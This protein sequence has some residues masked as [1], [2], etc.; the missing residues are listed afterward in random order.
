MSWSDTKL[1]ESV[2]R[3]SPKLF[4][5]AGVLIL[6]AVLNHSIV[7]FNEGY[8]PG[9]VSAPLVFVGLITALAG[10]ATLYPRLR[11]AKPRLAKLS[12]VAAVAGMSIFFVMLV[13][14]LA[15]MAGVAPN[16]KPVIA[17]PALV[18]LL[19]GFVLLGITVVRT[20]TYPTAVGLL[21]MAL[22]VA[23]LAVFLA[24]NV[25]FE[26]EVPDLYTMG[27]YTTQV[28]ILLSIWSRLRTEVASTDRT[29]SA[30]EPVA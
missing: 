27:V 12:L 28:V 24:A 22:V 17:V 6:L 8:T 2:E 19:A 21:L 7:L 15:N 13:W 10:A 14:A 25:L 18:L 30:T 23:L 4:L 5:A 9:Y 20:E 3:W 16:P 26:G 11:E 1:E 29:D